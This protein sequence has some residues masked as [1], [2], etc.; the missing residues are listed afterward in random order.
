MNHPDVTLTFSRRFVSPGLLLLLLTAVAPIRSNGAVPAAAG[1][2]ALRTFFALERGIWEEST[3]VELRP[4]EL[5]RHPDNPVMRRGEGEAPDSHRITYTSILPEGKRLRAWY[6]AM[7][8]GSSATMNIAYAE[9]EDGIHWTKPSLDVVKPGTNLIVK[10]AH[11]MTVAK[12]PGGAPGYQAMIAFIQRDARSGGGSGSTFAL[13]SSDDGLRWNFTGKSGTTLSHFESYGLFHRNDRWW[14]LGQGVAPY[15]HAPHG[16]LPHRVMYGL[17]SADGVKFE[18]YPRPLF[19]Y[20]ANARFPDAALQHHLGAAIW[21][22][23]RVMLGFSGQLWPASF[24]SKVAFSLGLM[25]SYEGFDWTEPFP[26]ATLLAPSEADGW[27]DGWL[28]QVQRPVSRGDTTYF[29]YVG[30]DGGNEWSAKSALGLATLRRDGF[31]SLRSSDGAARLI[32]K[33]LR[34]AAGE[35]HLYLNARG[36]V[37]V[38]IVDEFLHPISSPIVI[39]GDNV[40]RL[41]VDL[42]KLTI[43]GNFR[44]SMALAKDSEVFTFSLGP[45]P[46]LLPSLD[47]WE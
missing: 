5:K 28:L 21:D 12:N 37:D 20:P 14:V 38:R 33:P 13:A 25:Y 42:A 10:G 30:G 8:S 34:R 29:Y 1:S 43:S 11:Y 31:A 45:A 18:L 17:H 41:V 23:S 2:G 32:T 19:Y 3:G 24:S 27:D 22:R 15:L 36:R 40:R 16:G 7:Q 26:Q 44:V 9:S 35:T 46:A 47:Q 4:T 39:E 6:G